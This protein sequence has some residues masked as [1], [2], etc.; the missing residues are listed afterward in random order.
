MEKNE[1]KQQQS[2]VIIGFFYP[3]V[4]RSSFMMMIHLTDDRHVNSR[5]TLLN[6]YYL[7][8]YTSE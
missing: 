7:S 2:K 5:K 6:I 1:S 3:I 4:S 8:K